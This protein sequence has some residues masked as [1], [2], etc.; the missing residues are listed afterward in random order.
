MLGA[1][2]FTFDRCGTYW[3]NRGLDKYKA[4][5]NKALEAV[6]TGKDVVGNDRVDE[7]V[8]LEK[9]AEATKDAINASNA[10]TEAQTATNHALANYIEAKKAGL[11]TG[12]TEADLDEKLRGLGE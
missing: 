5:V 11:P 2:L 3:G 12:T 1:V 4:N 7:A 9:V 10:S 6:K 8:A